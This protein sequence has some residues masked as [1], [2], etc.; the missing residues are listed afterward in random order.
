MVVRSLRPS[1]EVPSDSEALIHS[2]RCSVS[3]IVFNWF[4]TA[5]NNFSLW[6]DY[7]YCPSYDPD[8]IISIEDLYHPHMSAVLPWRVQ[9]EETS[10]YTNKSVELLLNWQ[11]SGSS[12]KSND[13]LNHLIKEV[14]SHPE[15]KLHELLMFNVMHRNWKA[16]A[17]KEQCQF[18]CGFRHANIVIEVPS[19]SKHIAPCLFSIPGLCYCKITTLIQESFESPISSKFH[20]S[21]FKL[22]WKHADREIDEH[23]YSE[24][25]NSNIFLDV[26]TK[27]QHTETDNPNCKHEKVVAILIF[28]SD[29]THLATFGTAKM[30]PIYMLFGNLSKYIRCW[31]NSGATKHLAYILPFPTH[32]RIS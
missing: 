18:L 14:L 1:L 2:Q 3:L 31:P 23:I 25:Y 11:N 4:Q 28:W 17:A 32:S 9:T 24:V 29:A 26:H 22:Y 30:W 10:P 13:K 16:D 7:L 20:L 8:A 21:P 27:V 12:V 15:F 19:G 5:A 6:K